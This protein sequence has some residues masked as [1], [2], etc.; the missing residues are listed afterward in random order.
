MRV[1]EELWIVVLWRVVWLLFEMVEGLNRGL[2]LEVK[3][4]RLVLSRGLLGDGF[5]F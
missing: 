1:M 5:D 3:K 2:L 4:K